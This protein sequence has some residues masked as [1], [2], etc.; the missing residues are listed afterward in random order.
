MKQAVGRQSDIRIRAEKSSGYHCS[1]FS[2]NLRPASTDQVD[3]RMS[4]YTRI[5]AFSQRWT[6]GSLIAIQARPRV[7][8]E[9]DSDCLPNPS[10]HLPVALLGSHSIDREPFGY[11]R[12]SA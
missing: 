8:Q 11:H 6:K 9:G 7:M 5:Y 2:A 3:Y 10:L 12:C 1:H 4:S